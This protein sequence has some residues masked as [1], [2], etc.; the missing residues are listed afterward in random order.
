MSLDFQPYLESIHATYAKWWQLYT[1][2][3]ATGKQKQA[4]AAAP[5]VD[6]YRSYAGA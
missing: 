1:L 4:E 5:I 2:H 6:F 3:D